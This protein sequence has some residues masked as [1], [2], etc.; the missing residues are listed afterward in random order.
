MIGIDPFNV[1]FVV[2]PACNFYK[3]DNQTIG[4]MLLPYDVR[5]DVHLKSSFVI[6]LNFQVLVTGNNLMDAN[7]KLRNISKTRNFI[8]SQTFR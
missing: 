5:M 4:D 7:H 1:L 2:G 3:C 6:G 8:D